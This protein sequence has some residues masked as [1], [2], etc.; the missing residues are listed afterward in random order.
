MPTIQNIF[1]REILDG[2]GQPTVECS[3]W[4]DNGVYAISSAPSGTS[5]GKYE[6]L[7]LHDQ[8]QRMLGMGV[9]KA[10][11]NI[12]TVIAPALKGKDPTD[13]EGIDAAL[14]AL[15]G[16]EKRTKLGGNAMI[17]VSQV[18]MKAAALA[19]GVPLYYYIW[20]KY[21]LASSLFI[22]T[23]I[24]TM[25]NGGSHGATNLD[26]QE[27]QIV[28]ASHLD[29]I[30]SLEMATLLFQKL[31]EVLIAKGA[32]HSV[33]LDGGYAPNLYNNTDAFEILIETIKNSPYTYIQDLFFG[34]DVAASEFFNAGKYSLKDKSQPYSPRDLIEYY[35]NMRKLYHV[36]A[37]EDPFQE[38]DWQSWKDI[39]L[40]LGETST[41]IGDNLLVGNKTRTQKAIQEK[42]CN[43]ILIKPNQVGTIS[44]TIEVIKMAQAAQWQIVVSH[45]SGETNDDFIADFA[46]GVNANYVKFGPPNRGERISKYNRLLQVYADL[47]TYQQQ[48]AQPA[49]TEAAQPVQ[50]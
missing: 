24:Y 35:K 26:F 36:F 30:Q 20:Q 10:V 9:T 42:A 32:I 48:P 18:V 46:V 28:P 34:V 49:A 3:I 4:L 50:E 31:E 2:R 37:I 22:P 23:C 43:A 17:A 39:T 15:D 40:E 5:V 25:I 16:T 6:A 11:N 44:E 14:V 47:L 12:N 38:D 19:G 41:I 1:A 13:Q 33:G 29:F 8:E 27:F 7:D 45:R 21:Q